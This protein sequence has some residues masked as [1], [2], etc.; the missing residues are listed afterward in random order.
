MQYL[1]PATPSVLHSTHA[2]MEMAAFDGAVHDPEGDG[3][4]LGH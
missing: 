3:A 2:V 4:K 1:D